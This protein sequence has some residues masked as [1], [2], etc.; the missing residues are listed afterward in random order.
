[1][2]DQ[3]QIT[4]WV[5]YFGKCEYDI[6]MI[7]G[8]RGLIVPNILKKDIS[9]PEHIYRILK[10]GGS[11]ISIC[12]G[13]VIDLLSNKI[14]NDYDI[15]FHCKTVDKAEEIL[16]K[17]LNYLESINNNNISYSSSK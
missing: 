6:D 1:M 3:E 12:G 4:K 11:N 8:R 9:L 16:N 15:F 17:C 14:H 7:Y 5:K 10:I 13:S 2:V